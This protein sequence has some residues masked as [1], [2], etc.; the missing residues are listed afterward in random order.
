MHDQQASER[1][2]QASAS[3]SVV[4]SN[5]EYLIPATT[6]KSAKPPLE[7]ATKMSSMSFKPSALSFPI[8]D[9]TK[10]A[11]HV[12]AERKSTGKSPV[13]VS[14]DAFAEVMGK[15]NEITEILV[16]QQKMSSLPPVTI[17]VFGGNPLHFRSFIKAFEQGIESKTDDMQDRLYYLEQFTAGQ[18][19]NLVQSCMHMQ[20]QTAYT[21]AK[22]QL[23]LNFGNRVRIASAFVDKALNWSIIKP[24]DAY[25]LRAY[26]LFLRSCFNTMNEAGFIDELENATNMKVLVSKLPFR[27]RDRWRVA[28]VNIG[29]RCD[30][31]PTLQDLLEFLEKQ[32]KAALDPVYGEAQNTRER[33]AVKTAKPVYKH[34][35]N[36]ATTVV[37]VS[38]QRNSKLQSSHNQSRPEKGNAIENDCIFC[39][40]KHSIDLCDSFKQRPNKEKVEFI[41]S[42]GLCFGCL[43]KGHMSKSCPK[44]L[45]CQ[46]CLKN[47]P[48]VLHIETPQESPKPSECLQNALVS[49]DAGKDAGCHNGAGA[50]ALS[51]VPVKVKLDKGSKIVETYAFLDQGSTATF[52]TEALMAQLHGKGKKVE[53]MLKTMGQEKP[54]SCFKIAGL[55]VAAINDETYL[56]LPDVYTQKS[57]P[58]TKENIPQEEQIRNWPYLKDV[59]LTPIN[60]GIGLLIGVNCPK[61]LEPW[62]IVNS[63]GNGPYA[64]QTRLGW[65]IN[66]PLNHTLR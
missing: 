50:C 34:K 65:V 26:A 61:A 15:H 62:K 49:L 29:E 32:A 4:S 3:S 5:T 33:V 38:E 11:T 44:R 14:Y 41:K 17:P 54:V 64:V 8:G 55:E 63:E 39:D 48:T 58:V 36:F 56:K 7:K 30:R 37:P 31:R 43:V 18:P 45:S 53:I 60:A 10:Q 27:L 23:E 57:V 47:H 35:A 9:S 24:D 46:T 12:K 2:S 16:K 21:E 19:K 20:P 1:R 42:R 28:V 52:C 40:K 22:K 66:G 25:A 13:E 6:S 59:E 51:V